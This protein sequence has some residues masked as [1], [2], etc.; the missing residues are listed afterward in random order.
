MEKFPNALHTQQDYTLYDNYQERAIS[1]YPD[2]HYTE[3]TEKPKIDC[4]N[5]NHASATQLMKLRERL[6]RQK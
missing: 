1:H 3:D 6:H 2:Q 4:L 5:D